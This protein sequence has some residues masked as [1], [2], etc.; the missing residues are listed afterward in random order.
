MTTWAVAHEAV[1]VNYT[2]HLRPERLW[3]DMSQSFWNF[4][5]WMKDDEIAHCVSEDDPSYREIHSR[6]IHFLLGT[7]AY[8]YHNTSFLLILYHKLLVNVKLIGKLWITERLA[9]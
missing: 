4:L 3:R 1:R 8:C 9:V 7:V 5:F 2:H 6:D